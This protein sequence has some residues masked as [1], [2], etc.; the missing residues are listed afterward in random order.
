V[1]EGNASAILKS[2]SAGCPDRRIDEMLHGFFETV[3]ESDIN[4]SSGSSR[5]AKIFE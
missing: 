5:G 4:F 2:V 3:K 1:V